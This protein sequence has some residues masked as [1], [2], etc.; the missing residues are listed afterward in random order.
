MSQH[1]IRSVRADEWERVK[2]LRLA[3]LRDP[4]APVAFL[5]T[6]E[7]AESHPDEFWRG[8]AEGASHGRT[9]RQF[10]AEA[11]GGE[12]VGSV[13]VLVEDGGTSDLFGFPIERTQGHLVGVFVR[14]EHRGTGLT[15]AL[16]AASLEWAWSLEEPALERVRLFVHEENARAGAFYRRFG[17]RASGRSVPMPGNP[18]V[19]E[20]EYVYRRP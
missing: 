4:A 13:V 11:D 18:S 9:A 7:S 10:I 16:F 15:E 8:R 12:W 17:F 6:V 3:A 1:V 14:P 2:Q 20:L 5:E 19:K